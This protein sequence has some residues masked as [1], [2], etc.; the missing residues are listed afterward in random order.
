MQSIFFLEALPLISTVCQMATAL[1]AVS[2]ATVTYR[3]TKRQSALNLISQNNAMANAVNSTIIAAPE[4]C[5]TFSRLQNVI[6]GAQDDAVMFMYL[7]YVHNTFRMRQIG[8]VS[9]RI[10]QDTLGSCT[11]VV[12]KL[13]RDQ[14]Q[15]FLAR[16]Y[17]PAFQTAVLGRLDAVPA[18]NDN[19][20]PMVKRPA[21][22]EF[23]AA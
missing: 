20:L 16:G 23:A 12:A 18:R 5:A 2:I 6:I 8:A 4:A 9:E 22:L 21:G 15:R 19:V 11:A 14:V 3:Y 17:E 10:W 1:I 7:N 13:P